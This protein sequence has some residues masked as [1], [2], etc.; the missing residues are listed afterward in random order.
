MTARAAT[1]IQQSL[2]EPDPQP[3]VLSLVER[4]AANGPQILLVQRR[5]RSEGLAWVFPGGK[6]EPGETLADASAREVREEA[7]VTCRPLV[8][9]KVR[10]HPRTGRR[11][12]YWRCDWQTGDPH[13]AEPDKMTAARWMTPDEALDCLGPDVDPD[14]RRHLERLGTAG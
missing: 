3:V 10:T 4:M 8:Q 5:D 2:S 1:A 12:T 9:I 7:G 6:V 11:V 14:V 13:P